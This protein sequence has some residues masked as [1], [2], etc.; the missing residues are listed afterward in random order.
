MKLLMG[1]QTKLLL[2]VKRLMPLVGLIY[3]HI[4]M[5]KPVNLS[6]KPTE[7]LP[8]RPGNINI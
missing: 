5:K 8:K 6:T 4:S 3:I 7:R 1:T 2:R